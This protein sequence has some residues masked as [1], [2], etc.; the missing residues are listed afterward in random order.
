MSNILP[1]KAITLQRAVPKS[2]MKVV[3]VTVFV[4]LTAVGA[5]VKFFLPHTPIPI[6]LQVFFVLF[7]GAILGSR[8]GA[9]SQTAY[10]ALGL[11]GLPVFAGE[12]SGWRYLTGVSG[13]YLVGFIAAAYIVGAIIHRKD[14]KLQRILFPFIGYGAGVLIIYA[15]GCGWLW[16]WGNVFNGLGWNIT[17]VLAKGALP[18][19]IID[20]LKA[21]A[22]VPTLWI[23]RLIAQ[24]LRIQY[25]QGREE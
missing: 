3:G 10:V 22:A 2:L 18:F 6:T 9:L 1:Q 8:L 11:V 25:P 15:L 4:I 14:T 21:L 13:G 24:T 17:T 7:S 5:K 19:V 20:A 16:L 23:G 12:E